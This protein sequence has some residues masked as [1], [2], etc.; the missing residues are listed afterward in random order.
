M[1][2]NHT[3]RLAGA[4]T[5]AA[6]LLC[7]ASSAQATSSSATLNIEVTVISNLSVSVNGV[8]SSTDASQSW[9]TSTPG[10]FLAATATAT[11]R[12]DSGAQTEKWGLS[13]LSSSIDQGTAGS[14]NLAASL[15]AVGSDSY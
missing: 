12:N 6:A 13:T 8:V 7:L 11:V 3:K 2:M 5:A 9:N 1:N 10:A 15:G 14:W 4:M